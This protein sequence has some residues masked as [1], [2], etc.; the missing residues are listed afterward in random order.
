[1][2]LW[3]LGLSSGVFPY[4]YWGS[5]AL[6]ALSNTGQHDHQHADTTHQVKPGSSSVGGGPTS[7]GVLSLQTLSVQYIDLSDQLR[8]A[9]HP[10]PTGLRRLVQSQLSGK[11]DVIVRKLVQL[12]WITLYGGPKLTKSKIN[13]EIKINQ[14]TK[15]WTHDT[16]WI[17]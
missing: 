2:A 6:W 1:M 5:E 3:Y 4:W 16:F 15:S 10:R 7:V 9:T 14:Q 8:V 17:K 13:T 12:T 11:G